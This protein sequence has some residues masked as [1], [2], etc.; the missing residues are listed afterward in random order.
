MENTA[1]SEQVDILIPKNQT[2][3]IF[4]HVASYYHPLNYNDIVKS[5]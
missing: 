1:L 3:E 4:Y 2:L 5:S